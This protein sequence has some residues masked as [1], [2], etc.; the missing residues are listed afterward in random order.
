MTDVDFENDDDEGR[1]LVLELGLV[2]VMNE[3]D[4]S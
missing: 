2:E 1:L 4:Y 3:S